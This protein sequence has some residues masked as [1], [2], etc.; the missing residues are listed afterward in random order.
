MSTFICDLGGLVDHR[1]LLVEWTK[2]DIRARYK[3]SVL[4]IAWAIAQPL[5]MVLIFTVVFS[6]FVRVPTD[7]LPYP[8]F[9]FAALLPWTFFSNAISFAATS[10]TNNLNLVTKIYF[11]RE[12]LPVSAVIASMI[13]F[14]VGAIALLALFVFY[15]TPLGPTALWFPIVLT[16]QIGLTLGIA[17]I[18]AAANVF[19][20]DVRFVVP[21][22]TML[23]M[24]ATPV[25]YPVSIVPEGYRSIY[26]LN[27]MAGFVDA[28][29]N[30]LLKQQ[31]PDLGSL[32]S[33]AATSLFILAIGYAFFKHVELD[34]AD[35]I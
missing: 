28:Y 11:P 20:R 10:L 23:W 35:V 1:E 15:R 21:L 6:Y 2:R 22:A 5:S 16:F 34:F 3:Q 8:V 33:A 19:Y 7:G 4:G 32:A 25:I 24:Y 31:W 27:P 14:S 13:D 18:V 29:R 17:L 26:L 12:I 30:V 9:A